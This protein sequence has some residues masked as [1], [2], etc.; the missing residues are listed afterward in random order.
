MAVI[1]EDVVR[2]G[3]ETNTTQLKKV[4]NS[5]DS[6][7]DAAGGV[8]KKGDAAHDALKKVGNTSFD[9]TMSGLKRLTSTL[10]KVGIAAGKALAGGIAAGVAG[11]GTMVT[12]AVT[13]YADYEQL[14][15]GVDTLFKDASGTVQR[16][17]DMAY[18]TAGM[19]SNQYMQ[20]VTSFSAALVNGLGGDTAAAAALADKA[21]ISIADN[22]NKM[23][24]D[25]GYVTEAYQSLARGNYLM[26]DSLK[27]GYDGTKTEMQ[28]LLK[29]A[30]KLTGKKFDISNFAHIVEAIDA[31]QQS[32]GIA[33]TTSKEA[34]HTI[35]GSLNSMKSA[36]SNTLTSLVT[37]GDDFDRN[38][39]QLVASAKTF[40]KNIMPAVVSALGGVGSMIEELAPIIE[41]E[42]PTIINT[43]LP[44]L[45]KAATALVKGLIIAL[46]DIFKTIIGEVPT[47][48]Q[49]VWAGIKEAFGDAPGFDK[50]EGFFSGIADF[51][52]EN[53]EAIKKIVPAIIGLVGAFKLFNKAQGLLSFGGKGG[54][55]GKGGFGLSMKGTAQS[56]GS[57]AITIGGVGA[58]VAAF[59][60]LKQI[61]GYDEFMAGGGA[62][63]SQLCGIIKDIG[64]VG[65]ALTVSA[66]LIGNI[67]LTAVTVG[68]ANVAVAL[69]AM[70]AIVLAF[71]ALSKIEGIDE[72]MA[73]GGKLLTDLCNIIGQMA[74]SII[75][76][77]GE[78]VTASLSTIG[79][80]LSAF[81]TS[82][83]PMFDTFADV[84][85]A[86]LADFATAFAAFIGVMAGEKLLSIFTGGIDYA[87]LGDNL[88]TMAT[89]LK[90]FFST[91]SGDGFTDEA[92]AKATALFDCL[93][94]ISSLPAEGGVVGWFEGET[95]YTKIADGLNALAGT[96]PFFTA[97]NGIPTEAFT[98]ATSLFNC[99]AG[100]D[101]L[102]ADGGVVG[103]F[104]GEIDFEKIATGIQWLACPGMVAA[105]TT[106]ANIPAAAFTS[107]TA[108]FDAL[109]GIKAMP[110]EGGIAGWFAGDASTT[111]TN[112][113]SKLPQVATDIAAFFTALGGRTDFTPIKSLFNTLSDIKIDSDAASKGFLGLGQS[114]LESMGAGLSAFAKNAA[115]FFNKINFLNVENLK[116][117]FSELEG[118]NGLNDTLATAA[119]QLGTTL[120][121]MTTAIDTTMSKMQTSVS[122]GLTVIS[123]MLSAVSTTMFSTGESIIDGVISGMASKMP[124]LI[125]AAR[126]VAST[127][128][129]ELNGALEIN[130]PS[131]VTAEI[132]QY[133]T[134]GQAVGMRKAIPDVQA[135]AQDV[136]R[137]SLPYSSHYTPESSTT[138]YNNGGNTEYTTV[139]PVFN[140]TISGSQDDRA[141][142][143][144]VKQYVA[145]A[146]QDTFESLE[147]KSV[148]W[149][150]V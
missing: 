61:D 86:G 85:T 110:T 31:V 95:D 17:A 3:F 117:F 60:A 80:N 84:D 35:T 100:L 36:W 73:N 71:G 140:L 77:I 39:Q 113:S 42:L 96:A 19:S 50:I 64:L 53:G 47:I 94:G 97:I 88:N 62:A 81:A 30:E 56:L 52:S 102:P 137:A 66:G 148:V 104:M 69:G 24:T 38:L 122:T 55:S 144:R 58:I 14:V 108:M 13:N 126:G 68:M 72:F 51:F 146:I 40:G 70:E 4:T 82:I 124:T 103:W 92:F 99:L 111:L 130:S 48:L 142:A 41:Q 135:A 118:V 143:R 90:G 65:L 76:G 18:K 6:I 75:G 138:T 119:T 49:E 29:D 11:V 116:T 105:L 32:M 22:A 134:M 147:R 78:G 133:T 2:V 123:G 107:L 10:G 106:I 45:I 26:L 128:K 87:E 44:P 141:M 16:N 25:I 59:G 149:R 127:I 98:K 28:R 21:I 114:Q 120:S 34:E 33:G 139:S 74:G 145:Q 121:N 37:G 27:L 131:R 5:L 79:D 20:N 63:L 8:D 67:P 101:A 43:L 57:V 83:Q 15:G 125:L 1:R 136:G 7:K 54:K 112:V 150:E 132:G 9:K 12:K 46:P 109:A 23:G 93:A 129:D 89:G 91:I 115:S